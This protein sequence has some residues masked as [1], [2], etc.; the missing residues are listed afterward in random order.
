[1]NATPFTCRNC[2][3]AERYTKEVNTTGGYGPDLLPV[4]GCGFFTQRKFR[5]EVCGGCGLVEW[6]VAARFLE[7]VKTQ[8]TRI[9]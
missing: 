7:K 1:M 4:K 3:G 6:F 5:I 9:P 2:G 8:F